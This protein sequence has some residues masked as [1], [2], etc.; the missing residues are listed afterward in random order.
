MGLQGFNAQKS[1]YIKQNFVSESKYNYKPTNI[2]PSISRPC[3]DEC[4]SICSEC[5]DCYASVNWN[6]TEG[7]C[8]DICKPCRDCDTHCMPCFISG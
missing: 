3:C 1:K 2:Y 4:P 8:R 7:I 5:N 6:D